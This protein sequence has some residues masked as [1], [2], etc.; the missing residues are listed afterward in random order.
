M[1]GTLMDEELHLSL[2]REFK[3]IAEDLAE[4]D[5]DTALVALESKIV[6]HLG[7]EPQFQ[8]SLFFASASSI[9]WWQRVLTAMVSSLR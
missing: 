6:R 4:D 1:V 9:I 3:G 2:F 5:A 8:A 7:A